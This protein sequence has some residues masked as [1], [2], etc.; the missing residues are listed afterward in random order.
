MYRFK[1]LNPLVSLVCT[2]ALLTACSADSETHD[3]P[4]V[5]LGTLDLIISDQAARAVK[6]PGDPGTGHDENTANW[7]RLVLMMVYDETSRPEDGKMFRKE[8]LTKAEFDALP[9]SEKG[10]R[11]ISLKVPLGKVYL[12]GLTYT[13][14]AKGA[15]ELTK[16]IEAISNQSTFQDIKTAIEGLTLTNDYAQ[17]IVQNNQAEQPN[18]NRVSMFLSVASGYY[19][20]SQSNGLP[21]PLTITTN[22]NPGDALPTMQLSRLAAKLDVQWDAADAFAP[23]KE[24]KSVK[25]KSIALMPGNENVNIP[26]GKGKGSGRLFPTL[27]KDN[28][29][30]LMGTFTFENTTPISQRN[31]RMDLYLFPDGVSVPKLIYTISGT[32][33]KGTQEGTHSEVLKEKNAAAPAPLLPGAWYKVNTHIKGL[34]GLTNVDTQTTH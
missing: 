25:V 19:I 27:H 34:E 7:D 29:A 4:D 30:I 32:T 1:L 22:R 10:Y 23:D 15:E 3:M 14:E 13:A 9:L 6:L 8:S 31:G 2:L 21:A 5:P 26:Q 28:A 24:V 20:D 16:A 17:T 18:P 33:N 12:Y 11:Q